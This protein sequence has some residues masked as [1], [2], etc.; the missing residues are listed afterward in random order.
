ME[1]GIISV[2]KINSSW[3]KEGI[4]LYESRLEKYIKFSPIVLPDLKNSKSLTIET[5]KEEE[6]KSILSKITSSDYVVLMDERG[7][8]KTSREFSEWFQKQ[9]NNGRKRVLFVIGGPYGFS[10]SVYSRADSLIALSK[11][12]FTHEMAKLILTEQ[13][14]RVFTILKGEPYHHD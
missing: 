4:D 5:I 3:I 11:M 13:L 6:G 12:T 1:I 9:M 10:Q 14:Y 8:E 7:N 2:G